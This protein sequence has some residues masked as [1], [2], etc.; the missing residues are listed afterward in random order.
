MKSDTSRVITLHEPSIKEKPTWR[1]STFLMI[2]RQILVFSK[3][4]KNPVKCKDHTHERTN[5]QGTE[6]RQPQLF[7]IAKSGACGPVMNQDNE[8]VFVGFH[9]RISD[10]EAVPA[11]IHLIEEGLAPLGINALIL[12]FNPGFA[13]R[14]FPQY[15]TGT[16]NTEDAIQVRNI[17]HQHGIRPIPL[18]QC[19]SHQSPFSG[20]PWPLF[21]DHPEFLETPDTPADAAWPDFYCHSWCA[22]NDAIYDYVFPMIDELIE[23]FQ[24]EQLHI[25][26]D[27]V[28]EIGE[29]SC[30]RCK[31]KDRSLLFGRTV[32]MLHDHLAA[33][34]VGTMM[35][36]DRLLNAEK[37]GYQMRDADRFG[38]YPA[39]NDEEL[40]TRDIIIC[41]WHYEDHDHGYPSMDHFMKGGFL[42]IPAV[43]GNLEQA[44]H[45]WGYCLDMHYLGRKMHWPGKLGGLLITHWSPF[46][47]EAGKEMMAGIKGEVL[48]FSKPF[49]AGTTGAVIKQMSPAVRQFRKVY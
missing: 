6:R 3:M 19:L 16:F 34:G 4:L 35:W 37:M 49:S 12:E 30:P 23:A 5:N 9:T 39:F 43:A 17:C 40:I 33:Q 38:I 29:E 15:S 36:G 2:T 27:E 31:G 42:T 26:M 28:F 44:K 14:S 45:F 1:V 7:P 11:L 22:S 8:T 13:Y 41:D 24:P 25:G 10:H 18:F 47:S 48:D 32:Q 46:T 20:Q 21:L